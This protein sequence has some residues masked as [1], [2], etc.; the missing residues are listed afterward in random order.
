MDLRETKG[1][2]ILHMVDHATRFSSAAVV[3]S[4]HKEEIVKAILQH[5]LVL[6]GPPNQVLSDNGGESTNKL[7]TEMSDQLTIFVRST[8]GESPWSN[9]TTER[10]NAIL[11]NMISKLLLIESNKH[12]IE[13]ICMGCQMLCIT[14]MYIAEISQFLVKT[15]TFLQCSLI[16]HQC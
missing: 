12:T 4:K 2:K 11:E 16:I 8:A 15:R 10:H 1:H 9:R 5:C 7:L 6:F 3:K 14:V 13:I